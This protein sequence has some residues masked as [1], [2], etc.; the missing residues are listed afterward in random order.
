MDVLMREHMIKLIRMP[1]LTRAVLAS[2]IF[3][4]PLIAKATT[5]GPGVFVGPITTAAQAD[6]T[7]EVLGG[8]AAGQIVGIGT[9]AVDLNSVAGIVITR[10]QNTLDP[11]NTITT[12]TKIAL[13]ITGGAGEVSIEF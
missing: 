8:L 10:T 2:S 5:F 12:D 4:T 1:F 6:N 7:V 13:N 11:I 9:D 3:V